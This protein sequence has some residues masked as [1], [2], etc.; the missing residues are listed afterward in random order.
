MSKWVNIKVPE[1]YRSVLRKLKADFEGSMGWEADT[2]S[3]PVY[4]LGVAT[5]GQTVKLLPTIQRL[6]EGLGTLLDLLAEN[7]PAI[8]RETWAEMRE[9]F[10]EGERELGA[11]WSEYREFLLLLEAAYGRTA[12]PVILSPQDLIPEVDRAL[13]LVEEAAQK[14]D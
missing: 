5:L 14:R 8:S 11:G 13:E 12:Q 2:L 1:H 9:L 3:V 7:P 4:L 6:R 10:R